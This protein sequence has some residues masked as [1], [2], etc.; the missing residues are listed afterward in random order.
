MEGRTG[1]SRRGVGLG[2]A[3]CV[4]V[5]AEGG[6]AVIADVATTVPSKWRRS[7]ATR[8]APLISMSAARKRGEAV[9]TAQRTFGG[10]HALVITRRHDPGTIEEVNV[11]DWHESSTSTS[12]ARSRLQGQPSRIKA[13]GSGGSSTCRPNRSCRA[14]DLTGYTAARADRQPD[15]VDRRS[16]PHEGHSR[17]LQHGLPG[18]IDTPLAREVRRDMGLDP[19]AMTMAAG[20]VAMLGAGQGADVIVFLCSRGSH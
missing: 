17:P 20:F 9:V 6:N 12:M 3:T 18:G 13:S 14:T 8:R 7:W 10:L 2:A 4:K 16:L 15:P 1:W 11:E 19:D 5:V